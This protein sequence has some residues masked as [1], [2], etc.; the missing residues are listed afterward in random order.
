MSAAKHTPGPWFIRE[1]P[2]RIEVCT[3]DCGEGAWF[4]I[5]GVADVAPRSEGLANA[6]LIAAAPELLETLEHLAQRSDDLDTYSAEYYRSEM[7]RC[8][9]DALEVV[10]RATGGAL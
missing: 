2:N 7:R 3:D 4:P 5:W 6:Q 9:E 8:I 10:T 1:T